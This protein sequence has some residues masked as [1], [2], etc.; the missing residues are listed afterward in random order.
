MSNFKDTL[1]RD[2]GFRAKVYLD[3]LGFPTIGYGTKIEEIDLSKEIA[4]LWLDAEIAEKEARLERIADYG[5]LSET[6]KDVIRSMAYQMGVQ[7]V[8]NF[9][10][11][12]RA[13]RI[14][15]W[16]AAG[17]AMRDSRWWRDEKT[18][19]RAERMSVRMERGVW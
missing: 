7:G 1:M 15:D 5:R 6:R 13:I 10:D 4:E 9:K 3:H 2:E 11:M 12:W 19:R 17:R 14:R 8:K 16:L 18:Q